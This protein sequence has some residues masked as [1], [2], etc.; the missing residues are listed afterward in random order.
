MRHTRLPFTSTIS[1]SISALRPEQPC[2]L[3]IEPSS[4]FSKSV[5]LLAAAAPVPKPIATSAANVV[6][7]TLFIRTYPL[8][9]IFLVRYCRPRGGSSPVYRFLCRWRKNLSGF[10]PFAP[11]HSRCKSSVSVYRPLDT[12]KTK[13]TDRRVLETYSTFG[14]GQREFSMIS[15][16]ILSASESWVFCRDGS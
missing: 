5:Y 8:F 15:S 9:A 3:P 7:C 1:W 14:V 12:L 6:R 13:K 10:E 16:R 11:A 2:W 4:K